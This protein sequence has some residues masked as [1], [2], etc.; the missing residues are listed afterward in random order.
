MYIRTRVLFNHSKALAENRG[1]VFAAVA[2]INKAR[3]GG[4]VSVSP[5]KPLSAVAS[6][7][8]RSPK[9]AVLIG[10]EYTGGLRCTSR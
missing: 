1:D 7:K 4:S 3:A 5:S 8:P 2:A 9:R 6:G 10:I